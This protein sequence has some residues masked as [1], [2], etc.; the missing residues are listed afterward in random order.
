MIWIKNLNA[1]MLQRFIYPIVQLEMR[2]IF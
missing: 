2:I 1:L